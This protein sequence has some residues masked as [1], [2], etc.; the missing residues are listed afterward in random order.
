MW[1]YQLFT[2]QK[3]TSTV[4][5]LMSF[6]VLSGYNNQVIAHPPEIEKTELLLSDEIQDSGF[7]YW[8]SVEMPLGSLDTHK[9]SFLCVD[10]NERELNSKA[11]LILK[12][13][14]ASY[15]D[16]TEQYYFAK[17]ISQRLPLYFADDK[18]LI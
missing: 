12:N 16:G 8:L 15:L 1:F 5:L 2:D 9:S 7:T 11:S 18:V 4:F 3:W 6:F 17:F 10:S 13:C 14:T